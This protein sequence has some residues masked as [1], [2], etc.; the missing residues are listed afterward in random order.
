MNWFEI[1]K[2]RYND[3]KKPSKRGRTTPSGSRQAKVEKLVD[4]LISGK[5]TEEEY[6]SKKEALDKGE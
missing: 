2:V 5:I 3:R 4:D 1:I 6:K